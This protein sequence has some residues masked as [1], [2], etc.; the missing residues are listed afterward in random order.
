MIHA[1]DVRAG[2]ERLIEIVLVEDLDERAHPTRPRLGDQQRELGRRHTD[3]QQHGV[4]TERACLIDLDGIQHE[5]LPQ[6]GNADSRGALIRGPR[7]T[8]RRTRAR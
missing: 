5:V 1:D 3:D 8:P 2:R 7:R 6:H 4:G